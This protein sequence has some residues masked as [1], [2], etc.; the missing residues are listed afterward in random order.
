PYSPPI[1]RNSRFL[2]KR[3]KPPFCSGAPFLFIIPEPRGFVKEGVATALTVKIVC[4][5]DK[6][7]SNL[8]V[9]R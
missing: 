3:R 1:F 7:T 6:K 9:R 2:L 5:V 4:R 8:K